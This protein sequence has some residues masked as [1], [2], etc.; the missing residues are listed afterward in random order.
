MHVFMNRILTIPISSR[1]CPYEPA[2]HSGHRLQCGHTDMFPININFYLRKE[3]SVVSHNESRDASGVRRGPIT[4]AKLHADIIFVKVYSWTM[5]LENVLVISL[6]KLS[7]RWIFWRWLVK[8]NINEGEQTTPTA[9]SP[10]EVR[11]SS[12][13]VATVSKIFRFKLFISHCG[14]LHMAWKCRKPS[15]KWLMGECSYQSEHLTKGQNRLIIYRS[16]I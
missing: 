6:A 14:F 15:W 7:R 2:H 8:K 1:I 16:L 3:H 12:T 13:G 5:Y 10:R 4:L 11:F 9:P